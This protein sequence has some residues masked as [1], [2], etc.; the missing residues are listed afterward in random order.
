MRGVTEE[1]RKGIG[2]KGE[3]RMDRGKMGD[4]REGSGERRCKKRER[5]AKTVNG[6]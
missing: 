5:E 4:K 6:I 1:K 3:E 2:K